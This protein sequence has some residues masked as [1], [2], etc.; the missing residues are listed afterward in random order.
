MLKKSLLIIGLIVTT[1]TAFYYVD[2]V[3]AQETEEPSKIITDECKIQNKEGELLIEF[4]DLDELEDFNERI[5]RIEFER[6]RKTYHDAVKCVFDKA[7]NAILLS[8]VGGPVAYSFSA[9]DLAELLGDLNKPK[10]ACLEQDKLVE[11]LKNG[12]PKGLLQPL[13]ELYNKYDAHLTAL[14]KKI[15]GSI[16]IDEEAMNDFSVLYRRSNF[17]KILTEDEIQNSIVAL[18]QAFQS[19]KEL[20]SAFVMHVHFQCMLVNLEEFRRILSNVREIIEI[21]PPLLDDCSIHK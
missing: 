4:N 14:Y 5:F 10:K 11:I 8:T 19:L 12:G 16:T 7:S 13:L 21:I 18:D 15:E 2:R 1:L 9:A 17:F 3:V 20:R 6:A